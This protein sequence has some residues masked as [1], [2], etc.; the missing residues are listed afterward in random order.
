MPA[1]YPKGQQGENVCLLLTLFLPSYTYPPVSRY[2]GIRVLFMKT[3]ALVSQKGGSGK[4][5]L[6]VH[7][8]VCAEI[9]G[10][11]AAIIDLDPQASAVSWSER[12]KASSPAVVKATPAQLAGL[13]D[14]AKKQNADLV[15]IDTAGWS[16]VAQAQAVESADLVLIP[17]RP[18]VLDLDAISETLRIVQLA[19][20]KRAAIVLNSIPPYEGREQEARKVLD[21]LASVAPVAIYQRVAYCDA[22][23]DGRSVEEYDPKG[24][25]AEEIRALYHWVIKV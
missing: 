18:T 13:L 8:A 11:S 6:A 19:S 22:M 17:C 25:A 23:N 3:I 12:R 2:H 15:I 14:Q 10:Q 20:G 5:T 4:S 21:G 16:D 7:L 24:R 1:P 9:N